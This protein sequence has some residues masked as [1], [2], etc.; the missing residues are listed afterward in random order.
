MAAAAK[1]ERPP[2][3][4][5]ATRQPHPLGA[6]GPAPP[7][8]PPAPAEV[9]EPPAPDVL[10][11]VPLL[12]EDEPLLDELLLD[13]LLL[14][15]LDTLLL[16]EPLLWHVPLWHIPSGQ[17]VPSLWLD[18][19]VVEVAGVQSWHAFAGFAAPAGTSVPPMKQSATQETRPRPAGC[20]KS[21]GGPWPGGST[22]PG[23]R[24]G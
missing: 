23:W 21:T 4:S 15:E 12:D 8:E 2:G 16:E 24:A 17:L 7:P 20:S 13:E 10:L 3:V 11:D 18:H 6:P 5:P 19:V 22:S 1:G 14:E 9:E